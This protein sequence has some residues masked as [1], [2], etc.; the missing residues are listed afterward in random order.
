MLKMNLLVKT[1]GLI[2]AATLATANFADQTEQSL[3]LAQ[4]TDGFNA[5]T[6]YMASCFA[7]HSTGAA[8]APKVG[9]GNAA[10]WATRLEKGLDTVVGNAISGVNTMPAKGLC[11][12]C[13]DE[14]IRALV[15][16][17]VASSK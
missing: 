14:D 13:T 17:M 4:L 16:Y 11:F 12:T 5:E 2:A 10:V 1:V 15:E 9:E 7:C 6:T 3:Q 8:G